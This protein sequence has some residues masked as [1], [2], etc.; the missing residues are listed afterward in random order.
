MVKYKGVLVEQFFCL[1]SLSLSFTMSLITAT[2]STVTFSETD[3]LPPQAIN[4]KPSAGAALAEED[5]QLTKLFSPSAIRYVKFNNRIIV[6]PM[7]MYSAQDG[8]FNDFHV[9]HYG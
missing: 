1:L 9:A 6:S 8:L 4:S 2:I 7:C 5:N 3:Y